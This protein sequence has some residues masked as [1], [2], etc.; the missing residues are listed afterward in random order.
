MRID[1]HLCAILLTMTAHNN[2]FGVPT[3]T[4]SACVEQP[5]RG[6]LPRAHCFAAAFCRKMHTFRSA[7]RTNPRLEPYCAVCLRG[8]SAPVCRLRERVSSTWTKSKE[9]GGILHLELCKVVD[10]W[11]EGILLQVAAQMRTFAGPRLGSNLS[12]L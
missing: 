8:V 5:S 3:C 11:L 7:P 12:Q 4:Y 9:E 2:G 6:P 10:P 1:A